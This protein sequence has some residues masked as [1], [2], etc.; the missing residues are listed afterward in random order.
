MEVVTGF[1]ITRVTRT[2]AGI[3]V[4]NGSRDLRPV[5]RVV[6]ATGFRPDLD[7]LRE[8]RVDLD[9]VVESPRTLAPLID[10][11]VHSCGT[12]PPHGAAELQHPEQN[13]YIVGMKSYG[14]APT[15]LLRTGYEQ[16][17]SVVCALAGDEEG[18]R[19]VE[20]RLPETGVCSTDRSTDRKVLVLQSGDACCGPAAG[21]GSCC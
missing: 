9:A 6:A 7:L 10:P 17:R 19:R 16:V 8:L 3:V 13:F 21:P 2:T 18:A 11:N 15:F 12:V 20:L 4:S 5:D 14:R 1:G